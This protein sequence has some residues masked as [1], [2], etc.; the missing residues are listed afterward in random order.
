VAPVTLSFPGGVPA[1]MGGSSAVPDVS[2]GSSGPGAPGA[3]C[4]FSRTLTVT[5]LSTPSWR[6]PDGQNQRARGER[7]VEW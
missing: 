1:T 5:A 6:C 2:G 3:P 7:Q 4:R